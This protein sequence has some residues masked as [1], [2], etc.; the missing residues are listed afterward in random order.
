MQQQLDKLAHEIR[1]AV[2]ANDHAD[3]ARLTEAYVDALRDHWVTLER[4][5]RAASA[6]PK[7][8]LELLAWAREMTIL[9][10]ALAGEHV[11][12]L[13]KILRYRTARSLYQQSAAIEAN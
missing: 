9:Q 11:R 6:L 10:R 2:L 8:A 3:A 1:A 13:D 12:A 4:D 5:E 7:L